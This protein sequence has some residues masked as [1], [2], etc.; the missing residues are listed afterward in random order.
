VLG[1]C[2]RVFFLCNCDAG[3]LYSIGGSGKGRLGPECSKHCGHCVIPCVS[4]PY[5]CVNHVFNRP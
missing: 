4:N 5:D 1:I 2:E 3:N